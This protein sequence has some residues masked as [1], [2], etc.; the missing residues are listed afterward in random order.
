MIFI[1][2]ACHLTNEP[3]FQY[4]P[5]PDC[6]EVNGLTFLWTDLAVPVS[7]FICCIELV[8]RIGSTDVNIMSCVMRKTV[9]GI[10]DQVQHKLG[11]TTTEDSERLEISYLHLGSREFV[12][13]M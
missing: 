5:E 3:G 1:K 2:F 13:S 8:Y 4:I 11:C 7:S 9:F 10:S 12:L 6:V